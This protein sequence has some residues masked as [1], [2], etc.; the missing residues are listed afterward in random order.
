MTFAPF[1]AVEEKIAI[2]RITPIQPSIR[3]GY[4]RM[5]CLTLDRQAVQLHGSNKLDLGHVHAPCVY[6]QFHGSNRSARYGPGASERDKHNGLCHRGCQLVRGM[7]L[8]RRS[9]RCWCSRML[10]RPNRS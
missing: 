9:E 8:P 2:T 5:S 3:D 10:V 7:A 1:D 4:A 6:W